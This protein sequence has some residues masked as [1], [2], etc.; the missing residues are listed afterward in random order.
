VRRYLVVDVT[1]DQELAALKRALADP[2]ARAFLVTIGTLLRLPT[3]QQQTRVMGFVADH[4]AEQAG[5][6]S[7]AEWSAYEEQKR[8]RRDGGWT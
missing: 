4:F 3:K 5:H 6:G 1:D 7:F 8:R 2:E